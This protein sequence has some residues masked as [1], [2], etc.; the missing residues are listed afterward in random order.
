M[1]LAAASSSR[2]VKRREFRCI[3][4]LTCR[5]ESWQDG[6]ARL[7]TAQIKTLKRLSFHESR[8]FLRALAARLVRVLATGTGVAWIQD[9]ELAECQD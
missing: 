6:K 2:S 5:A 3:V 4:E 9:S 8:F 1:V 7:A